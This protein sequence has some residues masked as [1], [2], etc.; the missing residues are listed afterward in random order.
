MEKM[1]IK[2]GD[3]VVVINGKDKGKS[4][5]V[6][7]VLP[8]K[9]GVIIEKLNF[10]KEFIKRDQSKNI[11]GGIMEKE[12]PVHVSNVMLYCPECGQG[13]RTKSVKLE[14]GSRVRVC[15]KCDMTFERE[16]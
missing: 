12:A 1:N 10:V 15:S 8:E 2:K 5:K 11:Q 14:D 3:T 4:G 13:V 9:K 6:L 16:K 7:K